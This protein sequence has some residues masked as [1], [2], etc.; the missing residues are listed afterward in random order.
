MKLGKC[1]PNTHLQLTL[2]VIGAAKE[3]KMQKEQKQLNSTN[4][5]AQV[6]VQELEK[7]FSG[8][9]NALFEYLG[10]ELHCLQTEKN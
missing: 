5:S 1:G 8:K 9:K 7:A 10:D 6:V 2:I 3:N 4:V